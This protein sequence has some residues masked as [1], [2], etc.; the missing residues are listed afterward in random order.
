MNGSNGYYN[1]NNFAN[2]VNNVTQHLVQYSL[3]PLIPT[4]AKCNCC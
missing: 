3:D 2:C 4:H 1:S